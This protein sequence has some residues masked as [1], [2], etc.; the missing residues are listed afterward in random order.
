[1]PARRACGFRLIS[2]G[3]TIDGR[4]I[5]AGPV[6][7]VQCSGGMP[8][9]PAGCFYFKE[10]GRAVRHLP[11]TPA[12]AVVIGNDRFFRCAQHDQA[13]PPERQQREHR[14][15]RA[16]GCQFNY[17]LDSD[18]WAACVS[19][20]GAAGLA[21]EQTQFSRIS[22]L[23]HRGRHRRARRSCSKTATTTP[24]LFS[25]SISKC[26]RPVSASPSRMTDM[27]TFVSPYFACT[28]AVNATAS[29]HNLL[30]NPTFAGNV[31]NRGPQSVGIE[32]IG[33]GNWA[34]W[35]FPDGGDLH[36]GADRRQDRAVLLQCA[37]HL[38]GGD[39]AGSRRGRRRLVDG[40]CHRQRQG[41]YRQP[42]L[43]ADPGGRQGAVLGDARPRQLRISAAGL[44]RQPISASSAR[45]ATRWRR[46]AWKAA[47][48][49]ATG[50]IRQAPAMPRHWATTAPSCRASTPAPG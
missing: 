5:A 8:G 30:I 16:G 12:Y 7:Q 44:G 26:R 6:L 46:T 36:R 39:V 13:R 28:T 42:R 25:R 43:R 3:A 1:M 37:G 48:G 47:T 19:A 31:V 23:R 40:V 24:I 41:S 4:S 45:R 33:A 29:T 27:N 21:L 49:R 2:E 15:P 38:A 22:G 20:G 11:N 9:Q 18:F 50:C 17:V 14:L 35:Q 32:I 34:H 10:G